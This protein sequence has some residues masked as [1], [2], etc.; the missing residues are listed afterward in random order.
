M[1]SMMQ[2]LIC[3]N[4]SL[5]ISNVTEALDPGDLPVV[6]IPDMAGEQVP[7]LQGFLEEEYWDDDESLS[8]EEDEESTDEDEES[9]EDDPRFP[10]LAFWANWQRPVTPPFRRS[11][12][13]DALPAPS[14]PPASRPPPVG[15]ALDFLPL[16]GSKRHRDEDEE[17]EPSFKRQRSED[18]PEDPAPS[19]SAGTSDPAPSTS[20]GTSGGFFIRNFHLLQRCSSTAPRPPSKGPTLDFIPL[21]GSSPDHPATSYHHLLQDS[22]SDE[23]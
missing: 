6:D 17:E 2:S 21:G 16:G 19:T 8:E 13:P 7:L 10:F 4:E 12:P 1:Q 20:A 9:E 3:M 11:S 18:S 5:T 14:S 22:E 15:P 23:D